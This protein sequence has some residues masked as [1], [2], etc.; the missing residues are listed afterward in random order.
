MNDANHRALNWKMPAKGLFHECPGQ[1][2][3]LDSKILV[4]P[5]NSWCYIILSI[6]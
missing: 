6:G 4:G 5:L 1:G 2:Q 3:E